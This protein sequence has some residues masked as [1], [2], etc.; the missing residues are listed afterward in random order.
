M[1]RNISCPS[2]S[3]GTSPRMVRPFLPAPT[4]ERRKEEPRCGAGIPAPRFLSMRAGI[5]LGSNLGDRLAN[6]RAARARL[7]GIPGFSEPLVSAP[8]YETEPLDCTPG[9]QPFLNSVVEFGFTGHP[10]TLLE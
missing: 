6:L 2:G 9:S 4:R 3:W 8:L 7:A 1:C 5:A 10:I